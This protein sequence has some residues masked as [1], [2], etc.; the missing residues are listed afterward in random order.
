MI[1]SLKE[2]SN[3]VARSSFSQSYRL[4][5]PFAGRASTPPPIWLMRQAGRHL[6]EYHE[7]RA[8]AGSFLDLCYSPKLAAE[9]TLQPVRR[10]GVDAAIV[11][12]DIMV[13]VAATGFGVEIHAGVGPVVEH[14]FR[15]HEDLE[16]LRPLVPEEDVPYVAETVRTV[17]KELDVPLIGFAGAP[18]TIASYLIEGRSSRTYTFWPQPTAQY[19]Q[20]DLTTLSAVRTRGSSCSVR[21]LLTAA[22]RPSLSRWAS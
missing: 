1:Y 13:P 4:L 8:R 21:L 19:G 7:V 11:F 3:S 22:P 10:Y 18:F 14:P 20:T 12:S 9:V 2:R 15:R 16:R 6:P 5:A 17:V